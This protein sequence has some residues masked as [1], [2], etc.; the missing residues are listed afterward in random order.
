MTQR[1]GKFDDFGMATV[2]LAGALDAKLHAISEAGFSQVMLNAV[3]VTDHP[4]GVEAA[5]ACG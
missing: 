3:D 4:G 2:T 5:A 1:T